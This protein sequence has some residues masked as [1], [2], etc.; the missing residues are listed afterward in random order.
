MPRFRVHSTAV[1]TGISE[2][3]ATFFLIEER[4]YSFHQIMSGGFEFPQSF[5]TS[6]REEFMG[7]CFD[8]SLTIQESLKGPVGRYFYGYLVC[9][10]ARHAADLNMGKVC[11]DIQLEG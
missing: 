1:Y 6:G 10:T 5:R 8:N 7:Y 4:V 2:I 3:K 9:D 11:L